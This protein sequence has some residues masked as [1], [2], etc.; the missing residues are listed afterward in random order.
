MLASPTRLTEQV[1]RLDPDGFGDAFDTLQGQVSFSPLNSAHV[2]AVNPER[3]GESLLAQAQF[4]TIGPEVFPDDL[5]KPPCHWLN[6][7]LTPLDSLQTYK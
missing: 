4:M 2:G 6:L 7:A 3:F 1:F 5:L